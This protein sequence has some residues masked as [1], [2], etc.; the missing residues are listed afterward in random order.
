MPE[1]ET[2]LDVGQYIYIEIKP[3]AIYNLGKQGR[4]LSKNN[5][6]V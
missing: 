1:H 6:E 2:S 4:K 5:K 3:I